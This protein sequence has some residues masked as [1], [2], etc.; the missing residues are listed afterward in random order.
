MGSPCSS[1]H[2]RTITPGTDNTRDPM[3][4]KATA[5]D[6]GPP[7]GN[8]P[9]SATTTDINPHSTIAAGNSATATFTSTGG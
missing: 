1:N 7:C 9:P 5:I 4:Q 2:R 8:A 6:T 3:T